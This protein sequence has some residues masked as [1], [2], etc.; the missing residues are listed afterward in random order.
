MS[1]FDPEK[2]VVMGSDIIT[3]VYNE[4]STNIHVMS[5]IVTFNVGGL[6]EADEEMIRDLVIH[7]TRTYCWMRGKDFVRK[8]MQLGFKNKNLGKGICPT[9]AVISNPEVRRSINR[10]I[11]R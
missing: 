11:N 9:L 6:D 3:Q 1:L 5:L 2:L 8:Y 10:A 4:L 7:M